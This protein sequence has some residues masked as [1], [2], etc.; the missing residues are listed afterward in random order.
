[1]NVQTVLKQFNID[2]RAGR[3]RAIQEVGEQ[4]MT[5][6]E[7]LK[8]ANTVIVKLGGVQ[9]QDFPTA[10]IV[11]KAL[12]DKALS[13]DKY[14]TTTAMQYALEKVQKLRKELPFC[15]QESG[16]SQPGSLTSPQKPKKV[17]SGGDKKVRALEICEQNSSLS[18]GQLAKL[19]EK[20]LEITYANA[21]YYASRVFK[22]K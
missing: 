19:I 13:G 15:F 12:V 7:P 5:A 2:P 10:R 6:S 3:I 21:H 8:M 9:Q 16:E 22:R 14:D 4:I 1:M 20:E 18:N 11:A 17:R